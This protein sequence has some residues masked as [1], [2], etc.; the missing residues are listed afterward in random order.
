[1]STTHFDLS[2]SLMDAGE[3]LVG[4]LEYASDLFDAATVLR[5]AAQLERVLE[6]MVFDPEQRVACCRC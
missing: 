4:G 3:E 1:M 6:A 5:W 2:L